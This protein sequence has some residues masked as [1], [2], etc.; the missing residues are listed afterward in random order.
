MTQVRL[1]IVLVP[2]PQYCLTVTYEQCLTVTYEQCL[3][4]TYKQCLTVTYEQCLTV[5]YEQS[6]FRSARA[7]SA[8]P[9]L[10]RLALTARRPPGT[11]HYC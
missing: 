5:T 7:D 1:V 9:D 6:S 2:I 11:F 8:V 4:V 3:T 10:L